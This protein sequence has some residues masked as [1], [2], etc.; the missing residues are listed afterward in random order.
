MN[1]AKEPPEMMC[2]SG[3]QAACEKPRDVEQSRKLDSE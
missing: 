1:A 2:S 3:L